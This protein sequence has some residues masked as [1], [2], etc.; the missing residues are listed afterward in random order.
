M[1]L[2]LFTILLI[3]S[4]IL[5]TV[6]NL[7]FQSYLWQLKEYRLDRMLSY[8]KTTQGRK[9]IL[10]PLS[11]IKWVLI[12]IGLTVIIYSYFVIGSIESSGFL[13]LI[14]YLLFWFIW[15]FE[16]IKS[17]WVLIKGGWRLPKFTV[18]IWLILMTSSVITFSWVYLENF[19]FFLTYGPL[20][21]KLLTSVIIVSVMVLNL[22]SWLIKKIIVIL[23]KRK[24]E[25]T[26]NLIVIGITGSYGK[27]S[28][29]EYLS[30]ILSSR[31][32]VLKTEG[33]NNTEVAVALTILKQLNSSHE[34]FIVEMG[35]YKKGEIKAI[36]DIVHPQVGIIT[37]INQQHLELFGTLEKTI[38]A[39]FELIKGLRKQGKAIFNLNNKYVRKMYENA[40]IERKDL[41]VY[42]FSEKESYK[43]ISIRPDCMIFELIYKKEKIKCQVNLYGEQNIENVI[44]ASFTALLLGFSIL[45]VKSAV[46]KL[47]PPIHTM[48]LFQGKNGRLFI[49]DTFNSNPDGV[50]AALKYLTLFRQKKYLVLTPLIELGKEALKIHEMIGE[51]AAVSGVS[52]FLT[53]PNYFNTFRGIAKIYKDEELPKSGVILFEGKEAG[54]ILKNYV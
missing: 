8:L 54:K 35:A 44:G 28:T 48:R 32:K 5:R 10:N 36:C 40:Q 15:C 46:K 18:K 51:K 12:V 39:K 49:D 25:R 19:G 42:G 9:V 27:T 38:A 1:I 34:V 29:K 21:D 30:T 3:S 53:N 45:E 22:A 50:L 26:K 47:K 37:G 2:R 14:L 6:R 16:G 52:I 23:A 13:I 4:F 7:L 33:Y 17:V 41:S 31:Y 43:V 24:I 11:L 20:L